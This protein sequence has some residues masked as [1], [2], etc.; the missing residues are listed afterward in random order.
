MQNIKLKII[1]VNT[2]DTQGG[3]ARAAYRLH[4]SLLLQGLDSQMLV[5]VKSS[6][7]FRVKEKINTKWDRIKS[8]LNTYRDRHLLKPYLN[9]SSTLFT[10]N[11]YSS[12]N[13]VEEINRLK[14][15]IV[16]F[17]WMRD[18]MIKMQDLHKISAPIV[19]SM[20]D[21]WLF[22]GGCHYDDECLRYSKGCGFCKKLKSTREKDLSSYILNIKK[23]SLKKVNSFVA[24]GL[25]RWMQKEACKSTLLKNM[26][27]VHLPNPINT[28]IFKP[29]DRKHARNLWG[30]PQEK[31]IVLY[32]AIGAT[33]D[34]RKGFK[35]LN[36]AILLIDKKN[37]ETVVFGVKEP[38]LAPA[39]GCKVHYLGSLADDVSLVSL[40][41]AVDVMV[42]P[43]LQ[44]NLS[45]AIMESL[46]CSTPVVAFNIGGNSDMIDHQETGYLA[47][48]FES[49]DLAR[50]IE[51]VLNS[52]DYEKLCSNARE[53]VINKF[54]QEVVGAKYVE[55]YEKII[56]NRSK[57]LL[58]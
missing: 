49:T 32:G 25:S 20:H 44:E 45:N 3:A 58:A 10:T 5:R 14:P 13:L 8:H 2:T 34:P 33:A 36:E 38:E 18:G 6:G 26:E 19:W 43:S 40:Y 21:M 54:D 22:T 7:D 28:N 1:I 56:N 41:N 57:N 16:H 55:L 46:A 27:V 12:G 23:S 42:V 9:R 17:H 52:T 53:A 11:I 48:A 4:E 30:F 24:I 50:G 47:K 15:D 37:V 29:A 35:E 39:L 51:W 31:Q